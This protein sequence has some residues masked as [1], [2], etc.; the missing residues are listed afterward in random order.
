MHGFLFIPVCTALA[1][2]VIATVS[3]PAPPPCR[4]CLLCRQTWPSW[5]RLSRSICN[6]FP[7]IITWQ[8]KCKNNLNFTSPDSWPLGSAR[9]LSLWRSA[10]SRRTCTGRGQRSKWRRTALQAGKRQCWIC[11]FFIA[12][13]GW[14]LN[15]ITSITS[16]G[17][18]KNSIHPRVS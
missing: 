14:N 5:D 1:W 4:P 6:D 7:N 2:P 13:N 16:F 9:W 17:F 15:C 3:R 12:H 18:D 8:I 10:C 11:D